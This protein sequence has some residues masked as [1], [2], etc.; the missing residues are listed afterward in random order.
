MRLDGGGVFSPTMAMD[1]DSTE[2]T[3]NPVASDL[4][5]H[6]AAKDDVPS[7]S[8]AFGDM[9]QALAGLKDGSVTEAEVV[10]TMEMAVQSTVAAALDARL[11]QPKILQPV[12]KMI[13][14]KFSE[15]PTN[16]CVDR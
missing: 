13:T 6:T 11:T 4:S 1:F 10:R 8:S 7:T 2:A 3:S 15:A 16:W 5:A 12:V 14:S 9:E